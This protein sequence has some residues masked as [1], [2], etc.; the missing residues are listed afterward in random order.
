MLVEFEKKPLMLSNKNY[1]KISNIIQFW[2]S[3]Q[4]GQNN[5][6]QIFSHASIAKQWL[7]IQLYLYSNFDDKYDITGKIIQ[8]VT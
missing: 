3:L 6:T 1:F 2:R 5:C 4:I 7:R 8:N